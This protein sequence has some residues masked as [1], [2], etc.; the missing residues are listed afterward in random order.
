MASLI[1]LRARGVRSVP[2]DC[3]KANKFEP[4]KAWKSL[5]NLTKLEKFGILKAMDCHG[6]D[7]DQVQISDGSGENLLRQSL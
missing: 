2:L 7:G 6:D 3:L 4:F 5:N 1:F